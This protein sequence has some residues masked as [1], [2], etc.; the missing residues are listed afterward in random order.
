MHRFSKRVE[1]VSSQIV[2]HWTKL[3]LLYS[4]KINAPLVRDYLFPLAPGF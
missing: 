4:K 1:H 2:R 3:P